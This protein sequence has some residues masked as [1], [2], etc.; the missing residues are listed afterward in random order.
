MN[1][2]DFILNMF[3]LIYNSKGV[4]PLKYTRERGYE[5]GAR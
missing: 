4:Q 5:N 1:A 3:I 2:Y